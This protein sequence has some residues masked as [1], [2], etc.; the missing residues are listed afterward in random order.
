VLV[1]RQRP[2][3]LRADWSGNVMTANNSTPHLDRR[4]RLNNFVGNQYGRKYTTERDKF[5]AKVRVDQ[6]GCWYWTAAMEHGGY[7]HFTYGSKAGGRRARQTGAHRYSY[8]MSH[9]PIPDGFEVD[10]LCKNPTCVNPA[11]LEAVTPRVNTLRSNSLSAL[12]SRQTH[13]KRGHPFDTENT[14]SRPWRPSGGRQC[15]ACRLMMRAIR[16]RAA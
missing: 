2:S 15:K 16:E 5:M 13:C 9:G 14:E 10:H 12:R 11:H 6:D 3:P 4:G 1:A 7:G 8:E